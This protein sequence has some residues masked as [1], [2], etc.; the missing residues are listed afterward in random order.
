MKPDRSE[1]NYRS[2]M[3]RVVAAIVADPMAPHSLDALAA[4]A[5]FSPF[6]FHRLYRGLMGETV[7]ET[8]RR[9]RLAQAAVWLGEQRCSVTEIALAAGYDSPQ[10][11]TRAFRQFSGASPREFQRKILQLAEPNP[12]VADQNNSLRPE[13]QLIEQ[14]TLQV[15]G[16][17][18][19]GPAATIPHTHRHLR[20]LVGPHALGQ[21]YGISYGDP[22]GSGDFT[23]FAATTLADGNLVSDEL[24]LIEIPAGCYAS[25]TMMGPYTQINASIAAL[26]SLW[27][28]YSGYEPDDRPLLE[29]YR[30]HPRSVPPEALRTDLLIPVRP[31]LP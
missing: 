26:Y 14:G 9:L 4:M 19:H 20:Q 23:Y 11:F 18:H 30:N 31:L 27:L 10:A 24:E 29:L 22:E 6:H 21:W 3:A 7:M 2:R 16:L 5:H 15:Q 17:R 8:V 25:H 12:P 28:P 1:R 13:L